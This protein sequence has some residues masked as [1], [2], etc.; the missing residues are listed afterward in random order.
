MGTL[1]LGALN[2]R[3]NGRI[4]LRLPSSREAK[5]GTPL[6]VALPSELSLPV[7]PAKVTDMW[8]KLCGALQIK[9]FTN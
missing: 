8:V 3:V 4:A 2:H 6:R 7:I 1:A 9:L 5:I